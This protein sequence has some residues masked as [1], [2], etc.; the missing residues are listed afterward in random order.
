MFAIIFIYN[1]LAPCETPKLIAQRQV[2]SYAFLCSYRDDYIV[3][4]VGMD[5]I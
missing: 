4:I 1:P 3:S 5:S 2:G